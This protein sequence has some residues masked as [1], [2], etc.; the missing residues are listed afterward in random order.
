MWQGVCP[1][2]SGRITTEVIE[3][4]EQPGGE[5]VPATFATSSECQQCLRFMSLP[6][7]HAAAYHPES[8][9]FHWEDGVD[10]M[11]TGLWEF[12][13]YLHD[14]E[15]PADRVGTDPDEYWVALRRDDATL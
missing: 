14:G 12:H 9:T 6:L 13:Q 1:D 5:A 2:C 3:A 4:S 15:W 10:I 8:V 7:T 11:G